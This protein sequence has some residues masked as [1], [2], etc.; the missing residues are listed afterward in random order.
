MACTG[1]ARRG[2]VGLLGTV[3]LVLISAED[4]G[5]ATGG[6]KLSSLKAQYNCQ[7]YGYE[8]GPPKGYIVENPGDKGNATYLHIKAKALDS[9]TRNGWRVVSRCAK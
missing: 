2:M 9:Y 6:N 5:A 3:V 4:C 1:S 7:G 8:G